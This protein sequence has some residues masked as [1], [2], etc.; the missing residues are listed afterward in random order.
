[1]TSVDILSMSIDHSACAPTS[2]QHRR[3]SQTN[4]LPSSDGTDKP[5]VG[6]ALLPGLL[7][8]QRPGLTC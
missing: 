4:K 8:H 7:H 2:L 5:Q 6:S 3:L 1:M